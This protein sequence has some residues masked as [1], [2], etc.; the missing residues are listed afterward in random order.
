MDRRL[1]LK[2]LAASGVGTAIFHRTVVAMQEA[3]GFDELTVDAI[4]QAEWVTELELT[5]EERD[6]ILTSVNRTAKQHQKL[7]SIKLTES[8]APAVHFRPLFQMTAPAKLQRGFE[9]MERAL[10][11]LPASDEE[12][13]FLPVTELA[14]LIKHRKLTSTRLTRIY[15]DRLKKYGPMLRC[16]VT[17]TEELAM[18]QA[19]RADAEIAAGRYRSALHGIPWGAKDLIGVPGYPTS[20]GIPYL[21]DSESNHLA[22]VASRLEEAGAVLVAKL[23][24]GRWPWE[25]SG[26]AD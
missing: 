5:D 12:I 11:A 14:G 16:V 19:A 6:A 23:S 1:M 22:T 13:A 4:Q 18:K 9:P 10:P 24:L 7:R 20:W 8:T 25:I 3:N 21:K 15:L 26:L 2:A 17:L